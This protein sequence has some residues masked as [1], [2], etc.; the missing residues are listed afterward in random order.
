MCPNGQPFDSDSVDVV[1]PVLNEAHVLEKSVERLRCHLKACSRSHWKIV[2]V[3]NG[4]TDGT[5]RVAERL[6]A[7]HPDQV[8]FLHLTQRGRGRALRHAWLQSQADIVCYMDVDLSST[9]R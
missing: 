5:I 6:S 3:D 7:Q 1:I 4:S 8:R 2:I 9:L